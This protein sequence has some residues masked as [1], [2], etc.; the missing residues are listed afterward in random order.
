VWM[1]NTRGGSRIASLEIKAA[2]AAAA[3]D[4]DLGLHFT[5]RN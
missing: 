4:Q 2:T 5:L 1:M 3:C